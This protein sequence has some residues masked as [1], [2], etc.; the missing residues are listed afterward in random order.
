MHEEQSC[1]VVL[2][3]Q[4]VLSKRME[5]ALVTVLVEQDF[6]QHSTSCLVAIEAE[7]PLV[8]LKLPIAQERQ[9]EMLFLDLEWKDAETYLP[10]Y[11]T[12]ETVQTIFHN[13]YYVVEHRPEQVFRIA[14]PRL[15]RSGDRVG[16]QKLV[17][18]VINP[19]ART[20]QTDVIMLD[21]I[22]SSEAI[23][24][25]ELIINSIL[26]DQHTLE[27]Y[28]HIRRTTQLFLHGICE[29]NEVQCE[30]ERIY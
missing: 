21:A 2:D 14:G 15:P 13:G 25:R 6:D 12:A 9:G 7:D 19:A 10:I 26:T 16:A 5:E 11:G 18:L 17:K 22:V 24:N 30:S 28:K 4:Y 27:V 3:L 1:D 20:T 23:N 29:L 8:S